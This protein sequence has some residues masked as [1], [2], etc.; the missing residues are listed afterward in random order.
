MTLGQTLK[1]L[2]EEHN[3][4]QK[5]LAAHLHVTI[6]T[7][8]NYENGVHAP[9]IHTLCRLADYYDVPVDYLLGRTDHRQNIDSLNRPCIGKY[10]LADL[11]DLAYMLPAD[12]SR[13]LE[14]CIAF[15]EK[16]P[17]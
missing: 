17:R 15:I 9:D 7:V 1:K 14:E 13:H 16:L 3:L 10:T 4:Y 8:S 12:Y 2:R 6:G 11:M 5:M